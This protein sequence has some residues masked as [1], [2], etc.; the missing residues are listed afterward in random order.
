MSEG[1]TSPLA[2]PPASLPSDENILREI[3]LRLPPL[4]SS[5]PRASLVCKLWCRIISDP[6]FRRRFCTHHKTPPLLGFFFENFN[7]RL[8]VFTPTLAAPDGIPPA[9]FSCR[10]E[11]LSF[12]GCR[13]GL[14]LLKGGSKAVV[15]DPITNRRCSIDFSPEF[16]INCNVRIYHGAVLR[17]PNSTAFKLVMIFYAVF[18]QTLCAS[19]FESESGKWGEII[20][21]VAFSDCFKPS[22]LV[23]NT[24]YWLVRHGSGGFLQFDMDRQTL[25]VIQISEDIPLT[26]AC[27]VQALR[28]QDGGFGFA[29]VSKQR[30]QLWGRTAI[31]GNV[32][33]G[34]LQKTV[35][36]DQ[37]LP[38]RPSMEMQGTSIVG[39]DEES[40]T[41]FIWTSIGVFMIQLESMKFT[42]VYEDNC[43]RGYFPFTSFYTAGNCSS[44]L[45][46]LQN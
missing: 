45:F 40:N 28:T 19:V 3:L 37:L 41:I 8:H 1:P 7:E 23:G 42:K 17:D 24:L 21:T 33:R 22:V 14:A 38:L 25:A 13:H 36:L 30:I 2:A 5:L 6:D 9:R 20:S 16:V 12:L 34:V 44:S 29:V 35:E 15:W 43:I 18:E 46:T 39:Y 32:V 11:G 27:H 10:R 4:P 26:D 31:S